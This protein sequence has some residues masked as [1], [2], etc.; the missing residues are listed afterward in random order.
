M[1]LADR[2]FT[3]GSICTE[4]NG[5]HEH[6]APSPDE[7]VFLGLHNLT[8]KPSAMRRFPSVWDF[9]KDIV[10]GSAYN[11]LIYKLIIRHPASTSGNVSH[12]TVEHGEGGWR[13]FNEQL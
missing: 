3:D 5:A 4:W 8:C 13:I 11:V 9:W 6:V 10:M 7:I 2:S 1:S 12:L